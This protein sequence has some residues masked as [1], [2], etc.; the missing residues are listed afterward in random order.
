MALK[1]ST[2][3]E[4]EQPRGGCCSTR[5]HRLSTYNRR[6]GSGHEEGHRTR[7]RAQDKREGTG[8]EGGYRTRGRAQDTRDGTG[9]EGGHRTRGRAQDT[10]EGTVS[11][12]FSLTAPHPKK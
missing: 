10:R 11:L 1:R 3:S 9:H 12:N 8:H 4:K 5:K 6:E 7:E 2:A